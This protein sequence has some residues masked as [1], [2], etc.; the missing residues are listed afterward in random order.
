MV[1]R[2]PRVAGHA[3][4][5]AAFPAGLLQGLAEAVAALERAH[6]SP[7]VSA[8]VASLNPD[9]WR[10]SR[11]AIVE[12]RKFGRA[13]LCAAP[14]IA[15]WLKLSVDHPNESDREFG[16]QETFFALETLRA[17]LNDPDPAA[18]PEASERVRQFFDEVFQPYL[19]TLLVPPV[20]YWQRG[21]VSYLRALNGDLEAV[22]TAVKQ[23]A[24]ALREETWRSGTDSDWNEYTHSETLALL[25][26]LNPHLERMALERDWRERPPPEPSPPAPA[27]VVTGDADEDAEPEDVVVWAQRELTVPSIARRRAACRVLRQLGVQAQRAE[28]TLLAILTQLGDS[29]SPVVAELREEALAALSAIMSPPSGPTHTAEIPG[30]DGEGAPTAAM[31]R[32]FALALEDGESS[33]RVAALDALAALHP[34]VQAALPV[35]LRAADAD[36]PQEREAAAR[37]LA[38]LVLPTEHFLTSAPPP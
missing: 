21:I 8:L 17:L 20:R 30:C 35:A 9:H 25:G 12:L 33:V 16:I 29:S 1:I 7:V 2:R 24:I 15:G 14:A 37:L 10:S 5:H 26:E 38:R 32:L 4:V 6:A 19:L 11:S 3:C 34:P 27:D 36:H 31:E 13:S 23:F 18:P 28:P 22:A